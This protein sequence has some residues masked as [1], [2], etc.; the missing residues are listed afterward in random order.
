M[1]D[2]IHDLARQ[3]KTTA[4]FIFDRHNDRR[5][6]VRALAAA[7]GTLCVT[8]GA[9]LELEGKI[10]SLCQLQEDICVCEPEPDHYFLCLDK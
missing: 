3:I 10:C 6:A 9:A 8:C 2:L 4:Q 1:Y 7:H 5:G